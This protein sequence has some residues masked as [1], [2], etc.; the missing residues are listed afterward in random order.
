MKGTKF[1]TF[2]LLVVSIILTLLLA[3]GAY[4][5]QVSK[6][7]FEL[8]PEMLR[9][10]E[11]GQLTDEAVETVDTHERVENV[12]FGA[13]FTR[14]LNGDGRAEYMLGTCKRIGTTDTLFLDLSVKNN[15]YL[16]DGKIEIINPNFTNKMSVLKDSMLKQNYI[17]DNVKTIEIDRIDAGSGEYLTGII[18]A[19]ISNQN[20]Y[21]KDVVIRFEGTYVPDSDTENNDE[22]IGIKVEKE[23]TLTVDWYGEANAYVSG[24]Y[25]ELHLEDYSKSY[26]E[27]VSTYEDKERPVTFNINTSETRRELLIKK[28]VITVEIP[29]LYG[30]YPTRVTADYGVYNSET[31]T[32]TI[33]NTS[34]IANKTYQVTCIYPQEAYN[35]LQEGDVLTCNVSSCYECYNNPIMGEEDNDNNDVHYITTTTNTATSTTSVHF[36]IITP[37]NDDAGVSCGIRILD[38]EKING[39]DYI[40][41]QE[42]IDS[43]SVED[44]EDIKN[45]RYTVEWNTKYIPEATP[46]DLYTIY[47]FNGSD[48]GDL[49]N[50]RSMNDY[51]SNVGIY[52][53]NQG[54]V[55]PSSKVRVY[56]NE[57]DTLIKEFT[58]NEIG[59]YNINNP[60]YYETPFSNI[61]MEVIS[62]DY[63]PLVKY[64]LYTYNIREVDSKK[65]K[66]DFTIENVNAFAQLHTNIA[67]SEFIDKSGAMVGADDAYLEIAKNNV[68]FSV[69]SNTIDTTQTE[70]TSKEISLY[71]PNSVLSKEWKDGIFL[72]KVPSDICYLEVENITCSKEQ[73]E[74]AGFDV[75]QENG[76]YFIKIITSN[77]E[78]IKSVRFNISTKMLVNPMAG[79]GTARFELYAYNSIY[80]VYREYTTDVYDVNGNENKS[81]SVGYASQLL[82]ILAPSSFT[83]VQTISDYD[84]QGSI[85][86]APNIAVAET[87][88]TSAK[89]NIDFANNYSANVDNIRVLGKVPA[90]GSLGSEFTAQMTSEGIKVPS[91]LSAT[92]YYSENENATRDLDDNTNE[93]RLA[94]NTDFTK[95]K[96]Y[97]I[98]LDNVTV[99]TGN[100]YHFEYNI[101]IPSNIDINS[102]AY[103]N[104][105]VYFDLYTDGGTLERELNPR[106]V[107]IRLVKNFGFEITKLK[108]GQNLV[109]PEA[110]YQ[111]KEINETEEVGELNRILISTQEGKLSLANLRVNQ[112]Y[113]FKEIQAP[114]AY[115][116]NEE[117]IRFKVVEE[118]NELTI[119][120]LDNSEGTFE[121]ATIIN[122]VLKAEIEDE[123]KFELVLNKY[124]RQNDETINNVTFQ[125]DGKKY[126]TKNGQIIVENLSVGEEHTV[127]ETYAPGYFLEP[128][129][130]FTINKDNNGDYQI[131][132]ANADFA[133]AEIVNDENNHLINVA[134][135]FYNDPI[136]LYNLQIEKVDGTNPNFKLSDTKFL[137]KREDLKNSVYYTTDIDGTIDIEDLYVYKEGKSITG[138]YVLSEEESTDG[139]VLNKENIA[140]VVSK[141]DNDKLQIEIENRS[142]LTSLREVEINDEEKTVKLIIQDIPMFRL[143]KIDSE[144]FEPLTNVGFVIYELNGGGSIVDFA[145]DPQGNYIGEINEKGN[146][147]VYTNEQGIITASLKNGTYKAMEVDFLEG[148]KK[149][150]NS[151]IFIVSGNN[152]NEHYQNYTFPTYD[153]TRPTINI[154]E[155]DKNLNGEIE[156]NSI[157]DW[158][159]FAQ[160]LSAGPYNGYN[161]SVKLMRTLDFQ[162]DDSYDNPNDTSFGDINGN[163]TPE[164]IKEELTNE[165]GTGC[166]VAGVQAGPGFQGILDGQGHEIRNI[167]INSNSANV[168][169]IGISNGGTI[170]KNI[171]VTG[172]I[173]YNS[174]YVGGIIGKVNGSAKFE[175]VHN[176]CNLT[177]D[178]YPHDYIAG[179]VGNV[180]GQAIITNC[181]NSG[182]IING[183]AGADYTAGIIGALGYSSSAG[184]QII[185]EDCENTGNIFGNIHTAGIIAYTY[186]NS[187]VYI[188]NTHNRCEKIEANNSNTGGIAGYVSN[189]VSFIN[190]SNTADIIGERK[191]IKL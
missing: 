49:I 28:N 5:V 83:T 23:I 75:Y 119:E 66:E 126:T 188:K 7:K 135:D 152:S 32:L 27:R 84:E 101:Q 60:F 139:Y 130:T 35:Q 88:T 9:E 37:A 29:D 57:T 183:G 146:Y 54:L 154:N 100:G 121:N 97:L 174:D 104:H 169:L 106:K 129:F 92:I 98:V 180:T 185:I 160:G 73:V 95:V 137:F 162:D 76:N 120:Y 131:T 181:S 38:K 136:E 15:G 1:I 67:V 102:V 140:F 176:K 10:R 134:V 46:R 158:V 22:E 70:P 64:Q 65:I 127:K 128:E 124:D 11:Y 13:F 87:G 72:I 163:G 42:L 172:N 166:P 31:H 26:I 149:V 113:S 110:K 155:E 105:I 133:D 148:Y 122:N 21:R 48:N 77:E 108:E 138:R 81:E 4:S 177:G 51:I 78:P 6:E 17:S 40:S 24:N 114:N 123:P 33:T 93:W 109:V 112:E 43:Y 125:I 45:M 53:I 69:Y 71:I 141:D 173:K 151:E 161:A 115:E 164:T 47:T 18:S 82:T 16:R 186:K 74:I 103:G 79:A 34:N 150:D 59:Q 14:D 117:E 170:I 191:Y 36:E 68:E 143:M 116:L 189:K 19:A 132:S 39:I 20:D 157:E 80:N 89:I 179:I 62:D 52:F 153:T 85:T 184:G 159:R 90:E 171:T 63:T 94:S 50:G 107:G 86:V 12:K 142:S 61:R 3:I 144:T 41:K 145:K 165:N 187:N 147:V 44:E 56:D 178:S 111:L 25:K 118:N 91:G 30:Y 55:R 58:Y 2:N 8:T 99:M 156:I 175:N 190:C 182:T 168:G 167:Y 96:A